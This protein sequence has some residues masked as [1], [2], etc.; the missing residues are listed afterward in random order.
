MPS[1][2]DR[3]VVAGPSARRLIGALDWLARFRLDDDGTAE[4]FEVV[5][6]DGRRHRGPDAV[7]LV[8]SR[9]PLTAW[10][11]IPWLGLITLRRRRA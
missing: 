1:T 2:R 6:R 4:P 9:L 3:V 8:S 11:R 10:F 7:A 5:D